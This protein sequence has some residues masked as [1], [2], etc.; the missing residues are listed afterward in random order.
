MPSLL[1]LNVSENELECIGK[2]ALKN[3]PLL[4]ELILKTNQLKRFGK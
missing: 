4:K 2:N 3:L 1:S